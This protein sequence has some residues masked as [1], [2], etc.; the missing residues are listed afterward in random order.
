M[1][2]ALPRSL[3]S[4]GGIPAILLTTAD[5]TRGARYLSDAF[6][7]PIYAPAQQISKANQILGKSAMAYDEA[8]SLPGGIRARR[9]RVEIPIWQASDAYVDEMMLV[10]PDMTV[11]IGDIAMGSPQGE[12]WICPEGFNRVVDKDKQNACLGAFSKVLP[13]NT[14][15]LLASHGTDLTVG[16]TKVLERR[17]A[18]DT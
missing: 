8:A 12:L 9:C 16:V 7:C 11:A 2:P 17:V 15:C 10:L 18:S 5:H 4:L 6:S 13:R 14:T 3:E 1:L